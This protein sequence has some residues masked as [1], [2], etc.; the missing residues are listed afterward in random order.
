MGGAAGRAIKEPGRGVE[1]FPLA[2]R[3]LVDVRMVDRETDG[4]RDALNHGIPV[5]MRDNATVLYRCA[6]L[7]MIGRISYQ[8]VNRK[9][10]AMCICLWTDFPGTSNR[11]HPGVLSPLSQQCWVMN[12]L[13]Y[14]FIYYYPMSRE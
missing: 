14:P 1:D 4:L 2:L 5:L 8:K 11:I 9:T 13:G 12:A 3:N 10:L 7:P 6:N